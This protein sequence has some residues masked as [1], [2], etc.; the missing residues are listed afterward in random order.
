MDTS[1]LSNHINYSTLEKNEPTVEL[2]FNQ[3]TITRTCIQTKKNILYYPSYFLRHK[4]G[5][6]FFPN[7]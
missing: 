6:K 4:T 2:K 7:A 3:K 1:Y 5:R